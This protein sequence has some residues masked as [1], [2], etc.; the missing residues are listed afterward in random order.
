M[1]GRRPDRHPPPVAELQSY[2][3]EAILDLSR[4]YERPSYQVAVAGAY[5]LPTGAIVCLCA[6]ESESNRYDE[7][8]VHEIPAGIK[9]ASVRTAE[10]DT[11]RIAAA[12]ED[13][14]VTLTGTVHSWAEIE[15]VRNAAWRARGVTNVINEVVA[16]V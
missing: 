1:T 2:L 8:E 13:S 5:W 7:P 15:A 11:S 16:Q 14:R 3:Q 12:V 6:H 4:G 10:V 9:K